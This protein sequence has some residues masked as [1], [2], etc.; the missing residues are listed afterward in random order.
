MKKYQSHEEIP[1]NKVSYRKKCNHSKL[2]ALVLCITLKSVIAI[3]VKGVSQIF[4][5]V[6][7]VLLVLRSVPHALLFI[8][9]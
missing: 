6:V 7:R 5:S 8:L 2:Q 9:F 4:V 1:G 3:G